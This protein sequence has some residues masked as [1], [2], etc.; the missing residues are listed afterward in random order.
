LRVNEGFTAANGRRRDGI[1]RWPSILPTLFIVS[2]L[3]VDTL[4]VGAAILLAPISICG[5][6][7]ILTVEVVGV[8]FFARLVEV[9]VNARARI[10][11]RLVHQ[12]SARL[13]R[14]VTIYAHDVL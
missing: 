12:R 4:I 2:T 7:S 11:R 14:A 13:G 8:P 10:L 6:F 1:D 3:I 5:V 9:V